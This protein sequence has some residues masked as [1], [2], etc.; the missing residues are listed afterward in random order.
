MKVRYFILK[1]KN[2]YS[3]IYIRFWCGREY[4][5][6]TATGMR[7]KYNDW[8]VKDEKVKNKVTAS[9]KDFINSKL[10][11][12][13]G[14]VIEGFNKDYN[15]GEPIPKDWLKRKVKAFFNRADMSK[16]ETVYFLDWIKVFI[17]NAPK[18]LI[19]GK[20]LSQNTIKKY[21]TTYNKVKEFEA[22][23]NKKLTFQDI[24]MRFYYDFVDYCRNVQKLGTNSIFTHIKEIR[25]FCNQIEFEGLNIPNHHKK[26]DITTEKTEDIYLTTA[27]IDQIFNYDFKENLRLDNARDLLIIGLHTGLRVSD[28]MRLNLD[29]I[30]DDT[31]RITAKK[32]GKVAEI[33]MHQ[34]I[35]SILEKRG[36]KL[37][38]A[39]SE[40]KFN[41]YIKEIGQI[42]GF[43]TPTKGAKVQVIDDKGTKRKIKGTYP[44]YELMTSHICRRSFATNLYGEIPT[45]SIMAITGHSTETMFL[46]Y[47]KKTSSENAEVL[48][49]FYKKQNE[50][51]GR[52]PVLKVI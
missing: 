44:K 39:I 1:Q 33:P 32:T 23:T 42:L 49:N 12:L 51:K 36:G 29:H 24:T 22:H 6:K 28:F 18:R 40:Q 50:A 16:P 35:K 47:I 48:R 4:D 26:F 8:S 14:F 41:I 10:N 15:S 17:D 27:E 45:P 13:R 9:D 30:K 43:D 34:Q 2:P 3:Q 11:D 25:V 38:H 7:V 20:P 5:F 19:K 52:K 37:P 21:V 31:I 46:N